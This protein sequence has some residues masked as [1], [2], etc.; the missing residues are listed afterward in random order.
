[1]DQASLD[2]LYGEADAVISLHRSEGFGLVIAEAMLR[3]VP[4]VATGWSGN[5]DF[6]SKATGM[7]IGYDLV[8]AVDP[9]D[10][11]DFSETVWAE[12]RIE[13]AAQ[14]L[15]T[16]AEQSSAG[17]GSLA[18][19]PRPLLLPRSGPPRTL[20][21]S[22][23]GV[24]T[25]R[26]TSARVALDVAVYQGSRS[27]ICK[28]LN[29]RPTTPTPPPSSSMSPNHMNKSSLSSNGLAVRKGDEYD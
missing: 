2:A 24:P 29:Y 28:W 26:L 21:P 3:G 17:T 19:A 12:P 11:Y 22:G 5:T 10:T 15:R 23:V 4:V 14:A 13:E 20:R 9:Q 8:P 6:L 16:L 18:I 25:L 27:L 7:P 1:M